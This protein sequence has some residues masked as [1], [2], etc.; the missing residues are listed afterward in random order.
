MTDKNDIINQIKRIRALSEDIEDYRSIDTDRAYG[1]VDRRIRKQVR[2]IYWQY[3]SRIA[4]VLLLP[5]LISTITVSYLYIEQKNE[6]AKI[7]YNEVVSAP[8]TVTRLELPDHSIVWLNAE[9]RLSYP[10]AFN[11]KEREVKLSGEGYFEVQSDREYPFYVSTDGGLKVMAYGTKFNVNAYHDE[12]VIE[13]VLERGK[14]DVISENKRIQLE[15]NKQA[16]FDKETGEFTVSTIN[17]DEKTGWKEGR[18]VFRNAP[19]E[20]VLQRL[21]RRYNV[22]IVLHKKGNKAYNYRATFTTE[23]IEQI[24]N[25]LK[26]SAPIEWSIRKAEQNEDASF[27]KECIDVYLR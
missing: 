26:I 1:R 9:S 24:L 6:L 3:A 2:Q 16:T 14:I 27:P 13:A 19:L 25:Y 17:M 15:P 23:T 18:L 21:S 4:A 7:A 22:D 12:P 11:G 10:T 5:L 8:G 20:V